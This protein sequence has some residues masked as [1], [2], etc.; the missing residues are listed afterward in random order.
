[1]NGWTALVIVILLTL[2]AIVVVA[3]RHYQF[4][5][6]TR[7]G[8]LSDRSLRMVL[9]TVA[10]TVTRILVPWQ[11]EQP[12]PVK[13]W[14]TP[15]QEVRL[16]T[17]FGDMAMDEEKKRWFLEREAEHPEDFD[18]PID[19]TTP[20]DMLVPQGED[21]TLPSEPAPEV[22]VEGLRIN[23]G[24]VVPPGYDPVEEMKRQ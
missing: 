10:D 5:D 3:L 17:Q 14:L 19:L 2:G 13:E 16:R 8:E 24:I 12:E 9:D 23:R 11:P 1:M 7:Y 22:E 20:Y 18:D 15:E 6:A 4:I 21:D